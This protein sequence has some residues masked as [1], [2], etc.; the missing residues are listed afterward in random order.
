MSIRWVSIL[1]IL[2]VLVVAF[3]ENPHDSEQA[4]T[5]DRVGLTKLI[6]NSH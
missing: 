2:C 5:F 4:Q 1:V 6:E 3:F